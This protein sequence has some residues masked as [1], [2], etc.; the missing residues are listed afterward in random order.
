MYKNSKIFSKIK[1]PSRMRLSARISI[2]SCTMTLLLICP[3][4]STVVFEVFPPILSYNVI[5]F[6]IQQTLWILRIWTTEQFIT[7]KWMFLTVTNK[8]MIE[9][10]MKLIFVRLNFCSLLCCPIIFSFKFKH[11]MTYVYKKQKNVSPF[12]ICIFQNIRIRLNNKYWMT[13][14][15]K[16]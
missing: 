12:I 3:C 7:Q 6:Q 16:K 8:W 10:I 9:W 5:T 1:T 11:W 13:Y 2:W 15:C 4:E 14:V